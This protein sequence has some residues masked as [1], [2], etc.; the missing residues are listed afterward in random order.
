M[1]LCFG[2]LVWNR[3]VVLVL[4]G[5]K[6]LWENLNLVYGIITEEKATEVNNH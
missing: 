5:A 2:V 6:V 4:V 1:L 3:L